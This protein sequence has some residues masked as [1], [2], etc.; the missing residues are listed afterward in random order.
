MECR[1]PQLSNCHSD[2]SWPQSRTRYCLFLRFARLSPN[3]LRRRGSDQHLHHPPRTRRSFRDR[4]IDLPAPAVA[5][6]DTQIVRLSP[7]HRRTLPWN[8]MVLECLVTRLSLLPVRWI[9]VPRSKWVHLLNSSLLQ[10]EL[11]RHT[12][13]ELDLET[14][15]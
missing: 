7:P 13:Q 3:G 6:L 9:A 10:A 12:S 5:P 1:Q 2:L 14:T 4:Y 15:S 11:W 8:P